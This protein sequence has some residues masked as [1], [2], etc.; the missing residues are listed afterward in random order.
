MVQESEFAENRAGAGGGIYNLGDMTVSHSLI[1]GNEAKVSGGGFLT[2]SVGSSVIE[3]SNVTGNT[4]MSGGGLRVEGRMTASDTTVSGNTARRGGGVLNMGRMSAANMTISG[5]QAAVGGESLLG[6]PR[7]RRIRLFP[8]ASWSATLPRK[9][10][11]T[12]TGS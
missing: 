1:R 6:P 7:S 8:T 12:A 2:S 5:N 11:R 3:H 4:A 9:K 10:A